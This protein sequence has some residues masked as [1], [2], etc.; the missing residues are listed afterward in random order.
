MPCFSGSC[1]DTGAEQLP[2]HKQAQPTCQQVATDHLPHTE[3]LFGYMPETIWIR[4]H[5]T[6]FM[7]GGVLYMHNEVGKDGARTGWM[8]TFTIRQLAWTEW[9]LLLASK[10]GWCEGLRYADAVTVQHDR[11]HRL[12]G[13]V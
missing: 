8:L 4:G 13:T 3:Q 6:L 5:Q 7:L 12:T 9:I 2:A 10:R 11:A 1:S